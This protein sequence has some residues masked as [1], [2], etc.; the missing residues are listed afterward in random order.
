MATNRKSKLN[1]ASYARSK[2]PR[3]YMCPALLSFK[4]PRG[5]KT[6]T[7]RGT[8]SSHFTSAVNRQP[9]FSRKKIRSEGTA[10]ETL[11]AQT[12]KAKRFQIMEKLF[13]KDLGNFSREKL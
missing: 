10:W 12:N 13:K 3:V 6:I 2:V 11:H 5:A 8:F 7:L 4:E 1:I 9:W